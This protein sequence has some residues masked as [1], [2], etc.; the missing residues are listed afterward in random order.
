MDLKKSIDALIVEI[1][2]MLSKEGGRFTA[3][4]IVVLKNVV[5]ELETLKKRKGRKVDKKLIVDIVCQLIRFFLSSEVF[6]K[7]KDVFKMK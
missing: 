1:K 7:I 2:V 4:D 5:K 3:D 6:E